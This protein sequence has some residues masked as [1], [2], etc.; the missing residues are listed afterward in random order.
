M[1]LLNNRILFIREKL[2]FPTT[3]PFK[4]VM[5]SV[6]TTLV[7]PIFLQ[8]FEPD[9]FIGEVPIYLLLSWISRSLVFDIVVTSARLLPVRQLQL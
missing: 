5:S 8:P 1:Y 7:V 6:D 3:C 9:P 4:I 2:I